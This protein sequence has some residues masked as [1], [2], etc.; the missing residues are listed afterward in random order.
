MIF[1]E[2]P[3]AEAEGLLLAHS[4][5]IAGTTLKKG[6]RIT[7]QHV[8]ALQAAGVAL[9]HGARMESADV[10]ED[11]AAAAVAAALA[12]HGVQVRKAH[13][14]RC[15]LHAVERGLF[16]VDAAVIDRLNTVH[17]AIAVGTLPPAT[18]VR[19]GAVVATVKVIP[20]AVDADVV[21]RCVATATPGALRVQPYAPRRAAL[22]VTER[23]GD[24]DKNYVMAVTSS[25]RR[26]EDLGSHLGLVQRCAHSREA[27]ARAI[28]EVLA[29]GCNL[30]MLAGATVVKDRGDVTPAALVD[31][32]GEI[33][34][35]GMPVE[36]GNMLVLGRAGAV[37][38]LVLPGCARSRRLNGLDWVL[39]R[40]LAGLPVGA[41]EIGAMGVGGLIRSAPEADD[42]EAATEP[43]AQRTTP[44]RRI[45]ALV[46]AAGASA[47]MGTTNKLLCEVD[48]I[49]MV[50]RATGA[51]LASRC[52]SVRVVTGHDAEQ[53]RACLRGL[54]V[55]LVH[56]PR[57]A[58]GMA[59]SLRAG[60]MML[61]GDI[62]A[63]I[64]VLG[65]MPRVDGALV[66]RLIDAWDPRDPHIVAPL[67]D[68]RRGNP[69]LW[70]RAYFAE[71]AQVEGD[72]GAR[73]LL[74]RHAAK[75]RTIPWDDDAI[76]VDV[77]TPEALS[78][79]ERR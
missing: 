9:V 11:A 26:I 3:V 43:E 38:V 70:P 74:Q 51:A 62:D 23:A 12:G 67:R 47:R 24:P 69:I 2:F 15:N 10:G 1:G 4:L 31:A 73:D 41:A 29:A 7:A 34:R 30:V 68:G 25:R 39:Q 16:S 50:R 54:D 58:E 72:K 36:P 44:G 22:I 48:G 65:D 42:D 59:T 28:R 55:T 79:V 20:L 60:L 6:S 49:P 64:V 40:L 57:H 32:G 61:P 14:G 78:A 19:A 33:E 77:D 35:F 63:A 8:A 13:A 66:D 53:V 71:M 21:Q 45:A 5:R 76:F 17:E 56:N 46:L 52:G 18:A 37:P 75:V 27:V